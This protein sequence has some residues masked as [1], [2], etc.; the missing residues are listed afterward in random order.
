[1]ILILVE[2]TWRLLQDLEARGEVPI[3][4]LREGRCR[5]VSLQA[6]RTLE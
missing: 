2:E 5:Y 1:M 3:L 6:Y 4:V